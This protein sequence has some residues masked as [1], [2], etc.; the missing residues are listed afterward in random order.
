LH[1]VCP[2]CGGEVVVDDATLMD[3]AAAHGVNRIAAEQGRE[4]LRDSFPALPDGRRL[5]LC[6]RCEPEVAKVV[7]ARR[8]AVTSRLTADCV[9]GAVM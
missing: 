3:L 2:G 7:W 6:I 4:E 5:K 8:W 1:V 9:S